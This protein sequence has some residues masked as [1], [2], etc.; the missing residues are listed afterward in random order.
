MRHLLAAEDFDRAAATIAEHGGAWISAGAL[1]SLAAFADALPRPALE[2][3]PRALAHRAE[4]ARFREEFD[5]AQSLFRRAAALLHEQ[6]DEEGE[7]EALHSL[8]TLARRRGDYETAFAYLDRAVALVGES[9][10][11]RAKCGNTRGLCLVATGHWTEAEREFRHALQVAEQCGNENSA[12]QIAHSLGMPAGIRGDF[13]E[14]LRWLRRLLRDERADKPPVPPEAFAHLNVA[15]CHWHMGDFAACEQHLDRALEHLP[16]LQHGRPARR[17]L[18]SLRQPLPRA[19]GRRARRRILRARRARLRRGRASTSRAPSCSKRRDC[20]PCNSA[21]RRRRA[22]LLDRLV[23]ARDEAR[24]EMGLERTKLARG[25]VLLAQGLQ[26]EAR[27]DL[28]PA[29]QYFRAH[30]LYYNEAQA[31]M[32]LAVCE[33][34][35]GDDVALLEHLRR[36]LDLATRYDYEYWL[37]ARRRRNT[38]SSSPPRGG[39]TA[40]R[41]P[42]RAAPGHLR[43]AAAAVAEARASARRRRHRA[44]AARRPDD[45][46]ARRRRDFPRPGAR[47]RGRRV[48]RRSARATSCA[49]SPRAATAAPRRTRSSTPSGASRTSPPSRRTSTRPSRT[50]ARR[51]TATSR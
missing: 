37:G 15:R 16:A 8:A 48:G 2:A 33:H 47:F 5:A 7:A 27:A 40:P 23:A 32:L 18:R 6:G 12:R 14:A 31:A 19:A 20:S 50:S 28:Y 49:S 29:L 25:R 42:A 45:Q 34:E 41:R 10:I 26:A 38:R 22:R 43:R 24:D 44:G 1:A 11:V 21:T 13:G 46:H 3:H 39:G 30:G 51:S 17:N 36:A 4:V 9:S 35:A